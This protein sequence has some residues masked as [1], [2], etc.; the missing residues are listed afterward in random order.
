MTLDQDKLL[1]SLK[2][3]T[4]ELRGTRE[5]LRRMSTC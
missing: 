3:V 1:D 4:I 2:R 5:R